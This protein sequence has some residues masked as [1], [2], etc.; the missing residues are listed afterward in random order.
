M[1]ISNEVEAGNNVLVHCDTGDGF[2]VA[3]GGAFLRRRYELSVDEVSQ[4]LRGVLRVPV[5][6][7]CVDFIEQ[8]WA[9]V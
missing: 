2:T 4:Y 9:S 1:A 6:L 8:I 3:V 5:D 7:S